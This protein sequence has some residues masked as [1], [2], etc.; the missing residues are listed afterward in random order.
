MSTENTNPATGS[1]TIHE[2]Q[3]A[4]AA[5]L[6]GDEP[7]PQE[8]AEAQGHSEGEAHEDPNPN[9]DTEDSGESHDEG[10]EEDRCRQA[11]ERST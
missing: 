11:L 8:A 2:A 6:G 5:L 1:G 10:G 3:N 9:A 4:F 7:A